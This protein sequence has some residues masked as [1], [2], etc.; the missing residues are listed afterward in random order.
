MRANCSDNVVRN[1]TGVQRKAAAS[2]DLRERVGQLG[3]FQAMA[4][5]PGHAV[6]VIEIPGGSR[7]MFE[8]GLDGEQPVESRT[9]LEALVSQPDR[10][11][12]EHRPGQASVLRMSRLEHAQHARRADRSAADHCIEKGQRLAVGA[13]EEF[14]GG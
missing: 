9:D 5:R 13:F 2:G 10:R 1:R 4:D 8:V 3:I 14:F 6:R 7:I 12:E 11:L